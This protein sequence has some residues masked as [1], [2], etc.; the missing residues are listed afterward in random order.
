MTQVIFLNIITSH[1][2]TSPQI[3]CQKPNVIDDDQSQNCRDPSS[4]NFGCCGNH[5]IDIKCQI[6]L[7]LFSFIALG[8][9][10]IIYNCSIRAFS[11]VP[12][13]FKSFCGGVRNFD[14]PA[15]LIMYSMIEC[16]TSPTL[17]AQC[18]SG[19]LTRADAE[20]RVIIEI[21]YLLNQALTGVKG[22]ASNA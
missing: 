22:L 2:D 9:S 4:F 19:G 1:S 5:L 17:V 20:I 16:N 12:I 15:L 10:L 14:S 3:K 8:V 11:T 18:S 7:S 6:F 21:S 13:D